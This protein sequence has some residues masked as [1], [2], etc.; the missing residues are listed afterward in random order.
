MKAIEL[1]SE[2]RG[3]EL[4]VLTRCVRTPSRIPLTLTEEE[5][6]TL[7]WGSASSSNNAL[8]LARNPE[9]WGFREQR[10]PWKRQALRQR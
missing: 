9:V 10:E 6:T 2:L 8:L 1:G 3:R 4:L 7:G 5:D